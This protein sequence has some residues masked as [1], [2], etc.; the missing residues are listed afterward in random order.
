MIPKIIHFIYLR[1]DRNSFHFMMSHYLSIKSQIEVIKPEK[2]IFWTNDAPTERNWFK[3]IMQEY[4]DIIEIH[5]CDMINSYKGIEIPHVSHQADILKAFIVRDW[6]GIYSDLDSIALKPFPEEFY[7]SDVPIMGPEEFDGKQVGLCMGYFMAPKGAKFFQLILD[8]Y[9]DY[10]PDCAWGEFAV[11]RP[12]RIF[13]EDKSLVRLL[14]HEAL[15]PIYLNY[16]DREDLFHLDR[17]E[18][19]KDAYQLH[20]WE[21]INKPTM[22]YLTP[23]SIIEN[24]STYS[25]S[26]RKYLPNK[27]DFDVHK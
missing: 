13:N 1:K 19:L 24:N 23:R 20:L 5:D 27:I 3:L 26:V 21:N 17:T 8:E 18:L 22:K 4:G 15:E 9:K 7:K 16:T 25:Q 10:T 6:G 11:I 14:P 2:V 12:L